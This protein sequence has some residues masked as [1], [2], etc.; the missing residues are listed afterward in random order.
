MLKWYFC[1][2]DIPRGLDAEELR[3]T[4]DGY[5]LHGLSYPSVKEA[6]RRPVSKA[7]PEGSCICGRE[8]FRGSGGGV[9]D[10]P[11]EIR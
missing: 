9:T 5:G 2:A 10:H 6:L 7:G 4:A 11:P 8:H 3:K 1:K